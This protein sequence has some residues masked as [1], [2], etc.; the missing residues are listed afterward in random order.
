MDSKILF[1]TDRL[2]IRQAEPNNKDSE[3][4]VRLHN[5]PLVMKC[6]GFPKGLNTTVESEF[7][8]IK[9]SIDTDDA[10]LL[11]FLKN[12]PGVCTGSCKVGILDNEGYCNIDYKLFPKFWSKGYGKELIRGL[13]KYIF[14]VR[15]YDKIKITPNKLNIPSQKIFE[16]ISGVKIGEF[17]YEM[18]KNKKE[19]LSATDV[20]AYVYVLHKKDFSQG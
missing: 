1:E 13:A 17:Y 8:D 15:N 16:S 19:D 5:N 2:Y 4:L 20:D 11:V 18:P 14:E 12:N 7:K 6:V 9:K 10:K 3:L